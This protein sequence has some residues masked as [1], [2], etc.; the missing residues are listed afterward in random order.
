MLTHRMLMASSGGEDTGPG[1]S[2]LIAGTMQAGFFGEVPASDLLNARDLTDALDLYGGNIS[3]YNEPYLKFSYEGK[4][5]FISKKNMR[6]NI[7]WNH[8]SSADVVLGK[9]ISIDGLTY[10]VRLM[11]GSAKNPSGSSGADLHG[12][13]WNKLMLPIHEQ[14]ID[15]SW[16]Y[17]SNVE[18]NIPVW[19]HNYGSGRDGMYT[20]LDL[21]TL[22]GVDYPG[23]FSW[24][25]ESWA[26]NPNDYFIMRGGGNGVTYASSEIRNSTRVYAGWRPVLELIQ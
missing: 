6:S 5:Q 9:T 15:K 24:V 22:N 1:P 8:L 25:Q 12:S 21:N 18:W 11:S 4:I 13:E 26:G 20:D 14:S 7:S 2:R 10:K 19:N 3:N 16:E 17:P 23:S